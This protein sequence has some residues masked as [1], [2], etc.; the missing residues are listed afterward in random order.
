MIIDMQKV[1]NLFFNIGLFVTMCLAFNL[2]GTSNS[3]LLLI[4][5]RNN[6]HINI[7]NSDKIKLTVKKLYMY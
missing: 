6:A 1:W 4:L 3:P 2:L 5:T 7:I